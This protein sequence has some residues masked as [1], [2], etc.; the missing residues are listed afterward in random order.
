[1]A[2][3]DCGGISQ[4]LTRHFL[5]FWR[6]FSKPASLCNQ[7]SPHPSCKALFHLFIVLKSIEL[8]TGFI[9]VP[10]FCWC[11]PCWK[12]S[13]IHKS[14]STIE[15]KFCGWPQT[16][17]MLQEGLPFLKHIPIG[18]YMTHV[19]QL[20]HKG[21]STAAQH[22]KWRVDARFHVPVSPNALQNFWC[23]QTQLLTPS[24]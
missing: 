21:S 19:P 14:F 4:F 5:A 7:M 1:M 24:L 11:Q 18:W 22:C 17:E 23:N 15:R 3:Y 20:I 6:Q 12:Q 13:W 2:A 9:T 10:A 16:P 8:F